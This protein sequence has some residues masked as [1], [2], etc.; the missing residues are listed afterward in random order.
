MLAGV[1]T[2][3]MRVGLMIGVLMLGAC[4]RIQRNTSEM[5]PE[6][7]IERSTHVFIGVIEKHELPSRLAI[8]VSGKDSLAIGWSSE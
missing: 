8:R 4:A 7:M 6:Q 1:Y 5:T 3:R 2:L